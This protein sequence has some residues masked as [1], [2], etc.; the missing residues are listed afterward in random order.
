MIVGRDVVMN[1][2][3]AVWNSAPVIVYTFFI[4]W[5]LASHRQPV[6]DVTV[7]LISV[8]RKEKNVKTKIILE[9]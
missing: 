2:S 9:N 8:F 3:S 7:L 1:E 6:L 4:Y 5:R